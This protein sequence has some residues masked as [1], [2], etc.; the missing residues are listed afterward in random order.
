MQGKVLNLSYTCGEK[1]RQGSGHKSLT[2]QS[3]FKAKRKVER[4]DSGLTGAVTQFIWA[5]RLLTTIGGSIT[6][7]QEGEN[8]EGGSC[9]GGVLYPFFLSNCLWLSRS[10][11]HCSPPGTR[12]YAKWKQRGKN[13]W[14]FL[15][16]WLF[17]RNSMSDPSGLCKHGRWMCAYFPLLNHTQCP[18]TALLLCSFE[19]LWNKTAHH[20]TAF[21]AC[22]SNTES[23]SAGHSSTCS[24]LLLARRK[25]SSGT[26]WRSLPVSSEQVCSYSLP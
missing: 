10:P 2:S 13:Q 11:L 20:R 14:P 25:R 17:Q 4:S 8:T 3:V 23:A 21:I 9:W 5:Q 12:K 16:L 24:L 26:P 18:I 19:C 7:C 1:N 15:S 6:A 22:I